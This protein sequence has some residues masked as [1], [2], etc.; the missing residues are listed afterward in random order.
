MNFE[1]TQ[2]EGLKST[3][4]IV[5][6]ASDVETAVNEKLTEIG[7]TVKMPGFRPGRVPMP[8]LKSRFRPQALAEAQQSAM[9]T[10]VGKLLEDE[11]ITP[12]V[13]PSVTG[14]PKLVD[15]EDMEFD[16]EIE[17]LP[18]IELTDFSALELEL[19][20][21]EPT[22]D[23]ITARLE[24]L[25]QQAARPAKV[26][27]NRKLKNGDI[28]HIN[29]NGTVDGEERPGM[30]G[31]GFDL[32]LGSGQFIPGFEEQLVGVKGGENIDVTVT[33]PEDYQAEELQ[34]VAAVFA[35]E[36]LEVREKKALEV[37]DELV[38]AMGRSDMDGAQF[39]GNNMSEAYAN[40]AKFVQKR[41]LLDLL[42]DAHGFELPSLVK[43]EFDVIWQQI[44]AD[45][46]ADRLDEDDKTNLMMNCVRN[47]PRLLNAAYHW[48]WCFQK[49]PT[50]AAN[51]PGRIERCSAARNSKYPGQEQQVLNFL[52][53]RRLF[54]S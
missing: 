17:A 38:E 1:K 42:Q 52:K 16:L 44:E 29:F 31:E 25:G 27:R 14:E 33:F 22:E 28:A 53:N 51:H 32:E 2:S 37:G 49:L 50:C 54:S 5:V 43:G 35:V 34:G 10:A 24:E 19:L 41:K 9:N 36:V 26:A 46:A 6:P 20:K 39:M 12:A 48:V 30:K 15:G 47:T 7:K 11:G 8:V 45:K 4:H 23:E 21:V 18:K 13:Q 40:Q 3:F